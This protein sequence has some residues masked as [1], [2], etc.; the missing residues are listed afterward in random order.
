MISEF[1]TV[2]WFVTRCCTAP[3]H[4][5][6]MQ[7]SCGR[8]P[9]NWISVPPNGF[10]F[11]TRTDLGLLFLELVLPTLL[12][13]KKKN[14]SCAYGAKLVENDKTMQQSGKYVTWAEQNNNNNVLIC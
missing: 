7:A 12:S 1:F 5:I 10:D 2:F 6:A 11:L 8:L 4:W 14:V 3:T 13:V 9:L